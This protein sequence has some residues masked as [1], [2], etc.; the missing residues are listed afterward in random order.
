MERKLTVTNRSEQPVV[1]MLEPWGEDYW[2]QSGET[3]E[4][5]PAEPEE[6]FYFAVEYRASA[7]AVFAE[8]GCRSV[9]VEREGQL[10]ECG[11]QR[12]KEK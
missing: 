9:R 4:L 6:M 10:L 3:F 5:F 1:L 2:I 8:G 12:P 7:I 11:H